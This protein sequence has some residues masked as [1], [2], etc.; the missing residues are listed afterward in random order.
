MLKG[1]EPAKQQAG[2]QHQEIGCVLFHWLLLRFQDL[3]KVPSLGFV[4]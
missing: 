1:Y 3:D 2:H 4:V